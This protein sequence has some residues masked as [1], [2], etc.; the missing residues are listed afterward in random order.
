MYSPT[1][2]Y[3]CVRSA[4]I[5][6]SHPL[7]ARESNDPFSITTHF[8]GRFL[9]V[10]SLTNNNNTTRFPR[11]VIMYC[12]CIYYYTF[13]HNRLVLQLIVRNPIGGDDVCAA[14]AE[15]HCHRR[16]VLTYIPCLLAL[17]GE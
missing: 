15:S 2:S 5:I 1:P 9:M 12:Y 4:K 11:F 13:A 10:F 17:L 6:H 8:L 14:P 7:R 3:T 16:H